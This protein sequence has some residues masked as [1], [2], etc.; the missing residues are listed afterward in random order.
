MGFRANAS[1][2]GTLTPSY[3]AE[4]AF[5]P[6]YGVVKFASA[7]AGLDA[8]SAIAVKKVNLN[9]KHNLEDDFSIGSVAATDRLNKAYEV[10]GSIELLYSDRT[11]I[12]TDLMATLAQALRIQLVNTDVTIGSTSRP[13][14]TFDMAKVKLEEVAR[15]IKNNELVAQTLKF[16]AFYSLT[17]SSM[18]TAKLRN[19]Q[20]AVY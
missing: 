9:F 18:I 10:T 16:K 7:L 6:Q 19:L 14:L 8:A 5:L 15:S 11:Y 4:T 13:T 12:D 17:D 20:A 3:S 1:T 2:T